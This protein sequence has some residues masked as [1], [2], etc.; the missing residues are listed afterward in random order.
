M[1]NFKINSTISSYGSNNRPNYF[2]TPLIDIVCVPTLSL[3]ISEAVLLPA[4]LGLNVIEI[5]QSAPGS[6]VVLQADLY[7]KSPGSV[8]PMVTLVI[9]SVVA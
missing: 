2:P 3:I 4:T 9:L 8:P 1:P 6:S 5:V 7:G